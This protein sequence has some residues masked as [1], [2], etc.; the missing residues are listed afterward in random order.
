MWLTKHCFYNCDNQHNSSFDILFERDNGCYPQST[1]AYCRPKAK[2][3]RRNQWFFISS[4]TLSRHV[5]SQL[6]SLLTRYCVIIYNTGSYKIINTGCIWQSDAGRCRL[7]NWFVRLTIIQV[8]ESAS[9]RPLIT[10]ANSSSR[11]IGPRLPALVSNCDNARNYVPSQ[12][13]HFGIFV[14]TRKSICPRLPISYKT[15]DPISA[16]RRQLLMFCQLYPV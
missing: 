10:F 6:H 15:R 13:K 2:F 16:G 3:P 14:M 12:E 8:I 9:N 5:P 7:S 1:G 4:L 11:W